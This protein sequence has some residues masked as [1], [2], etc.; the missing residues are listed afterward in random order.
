MDALELFLDTAQLVYS[1][2]SS[3]FK[4]C[5]SLCHFTHSVSS[6]FSQQNINRVLRMSSFRTLYTVSLLVA[7]KTLLEIMPSVVSH[8]P[9]H[10]SPTFK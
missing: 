7:N 1:E 3:D 9:I 2:D 8:N 10:L 4:R 5:H 6:Q